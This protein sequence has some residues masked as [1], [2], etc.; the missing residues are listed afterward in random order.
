MDRTSQVVGR[1]VALAAAAM[2]V[3]LAFNRANPLGLPLRP[4]PR[5]AEA[6]PARLIDTP[7]A[8]AAV[9]PA[10][11][12]A[13]P[14]P[15]PAGPRATPASTAVVVPPA[16]AS[17][18]TPVR[19]QPEVTPPP[20]PPKS[21]PASASHPYQNVTMP[22]EPAPVPAPAAVS[23]AEAE[24]LAARHGAVFVD[25][26]PAG[27]FQAGAIPGAVSLP[28]GELAAG[29]ATFQRRYA[30]DTWLIVYCGDTDCGLSTAC[31]QALMQDYGYRR[32][33]YLPGGYTEWQRHR[34]TQP[35]P[36]PSESALGCG[37]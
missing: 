25:A 1:V 18:R 37:L 14:D 36:P 28:Y 12:P 35:E 7:D 26:R 3:G 31:A 8:R 33:V 27:A 17:V 21:K 24:V 5:M 22:S 19:H 9:A 20:A 16:P 15:A 6:P 32:V 34:A 23:W 11:A 10:P 4:P 30:A 29:I 2:V 13:A